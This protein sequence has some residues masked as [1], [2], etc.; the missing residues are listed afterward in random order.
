MIENV[1]KMMKAPT[2]SAAPESAS[3]AGVRT[4]PI[5]SFAA[6]A[7]SAASAAPVLTVTVRGSAARTAAASRAGATPGSA[8][9][10]M[11]VRSPGRWNQ[12]WTSASRGTTSVAPPIEV[13]PPH[14]PMPEIL[15]FWT[16]ERV[17][18][19]TSC[20][21]RRPWSSACWRSTT[22]SPARRGG[23]PFT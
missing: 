5:A 2:S 15:T 7:C 18:S 14:S 10:A 23:P 8:A 20:P 19:P 16:P 17:L 12:R 9:I 4:L 21:T 3:S 22:T 13:P 1:L 11:R 6:S